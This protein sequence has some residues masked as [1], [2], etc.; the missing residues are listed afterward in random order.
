MRKIQYQGENGMNQVIKKSIS[1]LMAFLM[2]LSLFAGIY[3]PAD[4]ATVDYQYGSTESY[5]NVIKNWGTRGEPA[6]FLSP[7]AEAFYAN[8]SYEELATKDG[9][10]NIE[11][12]NTSALYVALYQLMSNAHKNKTSYEQTKHLFQYTDSQAN[13]V[14]ST[15]ISAFYSGE[16]VGPDWDSGKTWNR[17]H[18]WPNSKG[19]SDDSDGGGINETD[20]IML[21]PETMN[22]NSSRGNK[23]Y[24]VSEGYYFPNLTDTYDVRGDVARVVLYTYV[25][26]GSEESEVLKNMW[27]SEGVIESK[28]VLL[29]WMEIDPVDTWE[30]GRNDSVQSITGTRNVFVDYPELAFE[31][32]EEEVPADYSTP[33]G[34]ASSTSYTITAQSDNTAYGTVSVNG[35]NITAY[36]ASGYQVADYQITSG[37]ATVKQNGNVFTVAASSDCT[38]VITFKPAEKYTVTIVEN[39]VTQSAQQIQANQSFTLPAFS[40]TLPEG[41]TF[42]GWALSSVENSATKPVVYAAGSSVKATSA[43]TFYAVASYF[44]EESGGTEMTWILVTDASEIAEGSQVIIAAKDYDYAM[45]TEQKSNNR[46]QA[47]ITKNSSSMTYDSAVQILTL[48]SGTIDGTY[49]FYTGSGYLYAASSTNNHLKTQTT[50]NDNGSFE[51]SIKSD[52][53]ATLTAQGSNTRNL[54]QYNKSSSLFSCYGSNSQQFALCLYVGKSSSGTTYYTTAWG[55]K[56]INETPV[57]TAPT[58]TEQGYTTLYCAD[59]GQ[60]LYVE[61]YVAALGHSYQSVVTA[62]TFTTQGYTTHT[63]TACGDSYVD[64]YTTVTDVAGWSLTLGSDLSVNFKIS[65]DDSIRETAKVCISV[66]GA[67]KTYEVSEL[68]ADADGAYLISVKLAAAQMTDEIAVQLINGSDQSEKKTYSVRAYADSILAGKYSEATK[69]LVTQMLHYGAAAQNYF[70]YHIERLANAGLEA[71]GQVT[72]TT[73]KAAAYTGTVD[74][75]AY[76][77]ATMLFRDKIAVRF[78]F[79]VTGDIGDYTFT[80]NG[81]SCTPVK[82]GDSY[83]IEAANINPQDLNTEITVQ[84]SGL[85]VSYSPMNYLV[86][87]N[88][89]GTAGLQTLVQALYAY[90]LAAQAYLAA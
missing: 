89:K 79:Q 30:M 66:A 53:T 9:S 46:G 54:M 61:D 5:P 58:C 73:D 38:I 82:K 29:D 77:G 85:T 1:V 70:N 14:N 33:S 76:S 21:R 20:I 4:A 3:I 16:E 44:D 86:N 80:V 71:P 19:G 45:S 72:P 88:R 59:C 35:N 24:G 40:G 31:L 50:L 28:D 32:F 74:G 75:V 49:A 12:V 26:W 84:V 37:S 13:G 8:T 55:C 69:T 60:E 2:I 7:N 63:C 62:P 34:S 18:V 41:Y 25:R 68:T 15:K 64:S 78:Y 90:H 81:N 57:D 52:G 10:S 42:I 27:G 6:T 23:A 39:G 47:A 22:N 87:M 56:H 83:Y 51:V 48:H 43:M 67:A 17:E 11:V 65:V 36:P